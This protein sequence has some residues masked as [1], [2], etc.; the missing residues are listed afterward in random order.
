MCKVLRKSD[1][2]EWRS[3]LIRAA[4]DDLFFQPEY[5]WL[6]EIIIPGEPECFVYRDPE[7]LVLYPYL[8][9]PITG[10]PWSDITSAYGYG[11]FIAQPRDGDLAAFHEA[12]CAY[13]RREGIVSEFVRFHPA[14]DNQANGAAS[15]LELRYHQPVVSVDY[16]EAGVRFEGAIKKE[17]WKKL[18]RAGQHGVQVITD[19]SGEYTEE[20]IRLYEGTMEMRHATAFY[21]FD[22]AFFRRMHELLGSRSVTFVALHEGRMIGGLLVLFSDSVGYNFLSCSDY[23]Y[24]HLGTNELLQFT[25]LEWAERR[26]LAGYLLGGGRNGEDSLFQFKAKFS[27]LRKRFFIGKRIHL[28]GIYRDLCN[29]NGVQMETP[30]RD[31]G[32][33]RFPLYRN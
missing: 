1:A 12:F 2:E 24:N 14:F 31:G 30:E 25:A 7:L 8:R 11:G 16:T 19:E 5:L 6:N 18:R 27:P 15:L 32:A 17:V 10:T 3:L 20:F 22:H 23:T 26:P 29:R 33:L 28:Q 9:R 4:A 13:C 21:Y